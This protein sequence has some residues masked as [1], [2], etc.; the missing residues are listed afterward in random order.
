M[1]GLEPWGR[2][3]KRREFITLLGGAATWPFVA[4]GQ[5]GERARHIAVLMY[6]SES[7]RQGQVRIA[8]FQRELQQ[9]GWADSRSI[10]ID[11]RWSEGNLVQGRTHAAEMIR[12]KPDLLIASNTPTLAALK[13]ET[14]DIPIV[15]T[16]VSDPVESGFVAS[17]ARPGGNITGFQN[18]DVALGGKWLEVLKEAAP[19]IVQAAILFGAEMA[20][21]LEFVHVA[22]ASAPSLGVQVHPV[23]VQNTQEIENSIVSLAGQPNAG[24]IVLPHPVTVNNRRSI[25]EL[26]TRYRLPAVYPFRYFAAEGGLISYGVDQIDQWRGAARYVDRILRGAKPADLPAQAP[27]KYELLINLR[28]AKALG[29]TVPPTL[30]TRADEVIE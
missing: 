27:N 16:Q 13:A 12:A 14:Q 2:R 26:A 28:T 22:E 3:M 5:E 19:N 18:S 25:I 29:L 7:D 24:L 21:N 17:L 11:Y 6:T 15:F 4:H 20:S 23:R 30:L 10:V 1:P 9:L 8:A